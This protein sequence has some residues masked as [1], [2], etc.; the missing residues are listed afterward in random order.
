MI[1]VNQKVPDDY[2]DEV[3]HGPQSRHYCRGAF[4]VWHP[5]IT[6]FPGI[7]YLGTAY[8]WG[9]WAVQ[10]LV[11]KQPLDMDAACA[12]PYLRTLNVV[13]SVACLLTLR[14]ILLQLQQQQQQQEQLQQQQ[15]KQQRQ[16]QQHQGKSPKQE[17]R[18]A[19]VPLS[20]SLHALLLALYPLH[21]FFSFLLYTDVASLLALLLAH[22][23]AL[24][25]RYLLAAVAAGAAVLCR[26]TNAV[27]AAFVLGEAALRELGLATAVAQPDGSSSSSSSSSSGAGAGSSTAVAE[28]AAARSAA[29]A[30]EAEAGLVGELRVA[31]ARAWRRRGRLAVALWPLLLPPAGFVVFLLKNGGSVV[32]GDK[33]AH[34]PVKHGAQLL[35]FAA[36]S[37]LM[38][39]PQLLPAAGAV[40]AAARRRPLLAAATAAVGLAAA[41]GVAHVS[42][43]VHPY[44][45]AD[46]RHYVF[47]LWRRL[48]N[49]HRLARYALSPAYAAAWA[50]LLAAARRRV[51]RL[52]LAGFA[53]CL[54][55]QLLPAWLLELRYFTPGFFLLALHLPPPTA[56]QA[57][58]L[59]ATYAAVDAAT[60]GMFLYRPFTFADGSVARFLW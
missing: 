34:K 39:W 21:W 31:A 7:Y 57:A 46:N 36:W 55:A 10:A 2:M 9:R 26:Q 30:A 13:L 20:P 58:G 33:E 45:L 23:A 48:I 54:L 43:L 51:S 27:W 12:T 50:L 32:L 52:W 35:Y 14:A 17:A 59:A 29:E 16:E 19:A 3:F 28:K 11:L 25:R 18:P 53:V 47:Y 60:M 38:L 41:A 40:A 8:G 4:D 42:T 22:L 56:L 44:M 1:Q 15:Q 6:T 5:K 49:R 24:R 37:A